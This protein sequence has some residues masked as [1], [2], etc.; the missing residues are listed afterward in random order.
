MA[1]MGPD[2]SARMVALIGELRQHTTLLLIEHDMDAVFKLADR[3]S[4]LVSGRVIATG[5]AEEIREN[6]EVRRAYLGDEVVRAA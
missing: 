1:G 2:E 6:A 5:M 4:V 3:I